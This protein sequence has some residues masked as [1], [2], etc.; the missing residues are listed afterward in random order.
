MEKL[1]FEFIVKA[2]PEDNKTNIYAITSITDT[3]NQTFVVPREYQAVHLHKEIIK[4]EIFDKIKSLQKRHDKRQCMGI[5]GSYV[6]MHAA[7]VHSVMLPIVQQLKAYT[8]ADDNEIETSVNHVHSR[9][10]VARYV[11]CTH[12]GRGELRPPAGLALRAPPLPTMILLCGDGTPVLR[13][14]E[15]DYMEEQLYKE[16][17]LKN[18]ALDESEINKILIERQKLSFS[19]II[20]KILTRDVSQPILKMSNK[21]EPSAKEF[22]EFLTQAMFKLRQEYMS[23]QISAAEALRKKVSSLSV[24]NKQQLQWF[25]DIQK[26]IDDIK[27]ASAILQKKCATAEK[28]QEHLKYRCSSVI[29]ALRSN[30][31]T[32]PAEREILHELHNHKEKSDL[33]A[34]QI[35]KL[36]EEAKAKSSELRKWLDEYKKKD[37]ALGKSRS[38][39][40][41]SILQQQARQYLVPDQHLFFIRHRSDRILSTIVIAGLG[42][43]DINFCLIAAKPVISSQLRALVLRRDVAS[44]LMLC[45]YTMGNALR[46]YST[47][48]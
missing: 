12:G 24:V 41:S 39:T 42:H 11:V 22:L 40:I 4:H 5:S 38:D 6:C 3:Q 25:A 29:R 23:R 21:E 8:F 18:P 9:A 2:K 45:Q 28:H 48:R 32:N 7:G 36:K 34:Q 35:K 1:R 44:L 26:E 27:L 19:S 17:Q 10:S 14:L 31:S 46:G 47:F 43:P 20:Q 15:P 13:M 37:I 30:K 16:I 33:Y